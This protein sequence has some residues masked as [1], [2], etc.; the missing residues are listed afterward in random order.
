M[1]LVLE[2]ILVPFSGL[3]QTMYREYVTLSWDMEVI[4]RL[5]LSSSPQL[6][7]P[8]ESCDMHVTCEAYDIPEYP[9]IFISTFVYLW[10]R[11]YELTQLPSAG[12]YIIALISPYIRL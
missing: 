12:G 5:Y 4:S 7:K 11:N 9:H 10:L 3:L 1:Q 2:A 8:S 6:L